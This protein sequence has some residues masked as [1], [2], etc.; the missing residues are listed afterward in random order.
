MDALEIWIVHTTSNNQPPKMDLLP[1]TF[2]QII[3]AAFKYSYSS[4]VPQPAATPLPS[5]LTD[6]Y[7]T[8]QYIA[9]QLLL[10]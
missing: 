6:L 7:S 3:L 8:E 1:K 10:V 9:L 2:L 5:L 4:Y